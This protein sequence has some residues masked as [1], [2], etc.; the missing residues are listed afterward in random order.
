MARKLS[1]VIPVLLAAAMVAAIGVGGAAAAPRPLT[2][3]MME[4]PE[5]VGADAQAVSTR[6]RKAG[7][8]I[9]FANIDWSGTAPRQEP[10]AW[11]ATNPDDKNYNWSAADTLVKGIAAAGFQPAVVVADAPV[12]A[13]RSPDYPQSPPV[14]SK[15]GQF[16]AAAGE[17]YSGTHAGLPRVRYWR[18]W[19]EPNLSTFFRPQLDFVTKTFTSPD[20][21]RNMVNSAASAL[22]KVHPDNVVIAG[23]TSPFGDTTPEVQNVDPDWGPLKFMRRLL[24]IDDAGR[25]T[26]ANKVAFDVWATHPYTS[27]SPSHHA[28]MPYDVSIG[29]LPEMRKTL[30]AAIRSGHIESAQRPRFWVT[31]FSWDSNP[32]DPCSPPATLLQRWVPE[33]V[34]RMWA[35]G[36]DLITW[37]KL[38]DEP[39]A[40]S[41]WQ[42]GLYLQAP[43]IGLARPKPYLQGFRFPFVALRR[44]PRTVFVWAHAPL[45]K[46]GRI[47]V[48]Q[49][50]KGGWKQL[51]TLRTDRGGIAQAVLKTKP[52]G[53]LRAV[54]ST[55]ER[56]LPFS[57][58]APH[59]RFYY[60]F[61]QRV[62]GEGNP[63]NCKA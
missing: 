24:C 28:N 10:K 5:L 49:T 22:H 34:Y 41:Y 6:L 54:L 7:V 9:L 63:E 21:Y 25:P 33:G 27:G 43:R 50:F 4:P 45:G 11:L 2:M 53:R 44:G 51:R 23:G 59:D 12:W 15:F 18:I 48:Q 62:L 42:S 39:I 57:M 55:G 35:S 13:R 30:D 16:L 31:E 26:C 36:I 32:P 52:V 37:F 14:D 56:S 3:A 38:M 19:N 60:P 8:T 61:G 1:L 47:T 29:D 58:A 46:P 20:V 40:T 17:R